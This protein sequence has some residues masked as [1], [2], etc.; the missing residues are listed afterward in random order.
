MVQKTAYYAQFADRCQRRMRA[1][2]VA[3][4]AFPGIFLARLLERKGARS[5]KILFYKKNLSATTF[6]WCKYG[7]VHTTG[8]EYNPVHPAAAPLTVPW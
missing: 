8:H 1:G 4:I 5:K 3:G 6:P 2:A 7:Q